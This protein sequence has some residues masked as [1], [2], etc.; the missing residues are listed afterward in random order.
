[1]RQWLLLWRELGGRRRREG[2][3]RSMDRTG[4]DLTGRHPRG[5]PDRRRRDLDKSAPV[6]RGRPVRDCGGGGRGGQPRRGEACGGVDWCG[7]SAMRGV[8]VVVVVVVV[9]IRTC[10]CCCT[11][12]RRCPRSAATA[13]A[14]P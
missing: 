11:P 5:S 12:V 4:R 8:V 1:M 13:T 14:E 7:S 2:C 3:P 6:R 10:C 9:E